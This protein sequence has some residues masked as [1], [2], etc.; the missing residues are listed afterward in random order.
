MCVCL[1]S[2]IYTYIIRDTWIRTTLRVNE[3]SYAN[4][5]RLHSDFVSFP[6]EERERDASISTRETQPNPQTPI[7]PV[8]GEVGVGLLVGY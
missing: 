7:A 5:A 2:Y 3:F 6:G 1:C 4:A 8:D